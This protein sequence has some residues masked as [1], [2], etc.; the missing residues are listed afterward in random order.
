MGDTSEIEEYSPQHGFLTN[1]KLGRF[2]AGY[3]DYMIEKGDA[4]HNT[5]SLEKSDVMSVYGGFTHS[6]NADDNGVK[7]SGGSISFAVY[8]GFGT[9]GA[10]NNKVEL[11]NV[12]VSGSVYGGNTTSGDASGNVVSLSNRTTFSYSLYA[13]FTGDGDAIGNKL[14]LT[15]ISQEIYGIYSS[16]T[17]KGQAGGEVKLT[18]SQVRYVYGGKT[19]AGT[20]N[21]SKVTG[22]NSKV[23]DSVYGGRQGT[24]GASSNTVDL[25]NVQ[26][27]AAHSAATL[28]SG[29]AQIMQNPFQWNDVTGDLYAGYTENGNATGIDPLRN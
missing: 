6:G 13:G 4:L 25:N 29:D 24:T 23:G 22:T 5:V 8:G 16:Y 27:T 21:D 10:S 2:L 9:T 26:V 1:S 11:D 28:D 14:T 12:T 19:D 7:G 18:N 17:K 15:D 3:G 20:A